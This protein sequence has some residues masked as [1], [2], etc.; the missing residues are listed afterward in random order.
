M[1]LRPYI[2]SFI[3]M[4]L[5]SATLFAQFQGQMRQV[6]PP[7]SEQQQ[8]QQP[9][10]SL[11]AGSTREPYS[12][13]RYFKSLAGKDSM[14]IARMWGGSLLLPGTAQ[15]Y[16]K[17][18]WKIPVVYASIGGFMYAGYK[19]NLQWLDTHESSY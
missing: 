3:L 1:N 19:S 11:Y 17:E 7:G 14:N 5:C 16:N 4:L 9:Q 18:Y 6:G 2:I 15:L 13:K 12:L 8:Q 10:D